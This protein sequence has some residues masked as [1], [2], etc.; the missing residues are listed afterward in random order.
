MENKLT[1][2]QTRTLFFLLA[3]G[4]HLAS[5]LLYPQNRQGGNFVSSD[6]YDL[7]GLVALIPTFSY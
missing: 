4:F 1:I 7:F 6:F 5:F 2:R 3:V